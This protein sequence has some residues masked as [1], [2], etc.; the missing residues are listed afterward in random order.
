MVILPSSHRGV[1]DYP[2]GKFFDRQLGIIFERQI[3]AYQGF[4]E[5]LEGLQL[6]SMGYWLL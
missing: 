6:K 1:A 5:A 3:V 2:A 4:C